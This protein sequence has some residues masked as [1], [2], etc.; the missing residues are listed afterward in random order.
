MTEVYHYD[1]QKHRD[2]SLKY[3]L[4]FL[5]TLSSAIETDSEY[6]RPASAYIIVWN[7]L[8]FTVLFNQN[9]PSFPGWWSVIQPHHNLQPSWLFKVK[10]NRTFIA[11]SSPFLCRP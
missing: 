4:L 7:Q 11:T 5:V 1:P 9:D 10:S 6:S 8:L 3:F 2:K